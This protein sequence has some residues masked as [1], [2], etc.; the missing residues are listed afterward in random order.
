MLQNMNGDVSGG[1]AELVELLKGEECVD[2]WL[3]Y[4][5]KHGWLLLDRSIS[6]N[7]PGIGGNSTLRFIRLSDWRMIAVPRERW[8]DG[9][10]TSR[11]GAMTPEEKTKVHALLLEW[12]RRHGDWLVQKRCKEGIPR[13]LCQRARV[14]T[15]EP[16]VAT[17]EDI[18]L[19]LA[20]SDL[21][22]GS[23]LSFD[24]LL[25]KLCEE[26]GSYHASRLISARL[27]ER[28]ATIFYEGLGDVVR[29]TSIEQIKNATQGDW[30]D[31]DL[32]VGYPVD[33]KN[34]RSTINGGQH[35]SEHAVPKFKQDRMGGQDVRI[36]G[37]RSPYISDPVDVACGERRDD[38]TFLGEVSATD[39]DRLERWAESKFGHLL[40]IRLWTPNRIPGWL[41][42]YPDRYY[43]GR[44]EAVTLMQVLMQTGHSEWLLPGQ[45]LVAKALGQGLGAPFNQDQ[46]PTELGELIETC[47]LAKRCLIVY[48]MGATLRAL[49]DGEDAVSLI[50]RI[51]KA[52]SIGQSSHS[53]WN[54]CGLEDPLGYVDRFLWA[55]TELADGIEPYISSIRIFRLTGPEVLIAEMKDGSR[56]TMLAYCGGWVVDKGRC[57]SSPLVVGR[58]EHCGKC[59]HLICSDCFFCSEK[60]KPEHALRRQS[61]HT[62]ARAI[63]GAYTEMSDDLEG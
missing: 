8:H 52:V 40:V 46:L 17:N 63:W 53:G 13:L 9:S 43:K 12:R 19:C 38:V 44:A 39:I 34:S 5:P 28:C 60:C 55:F 21:N 16:P 3:G 30:R 42:E 57:G 33:V 31:F 51:R 4:S 49:I 15:E 29:D 56:W 6:G 24:T 25:R 20:W 35:Y 14:S 50:A 62:K 22:V 27:A 1:S 36:V 48:A 54:A 23:D 2:H 32:D 18:L 37:I 58:Q 41:F 26:I 11:L 61:A 59:R 45:W 47:G 10:I 7:E